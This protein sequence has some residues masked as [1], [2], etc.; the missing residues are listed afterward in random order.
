MT[1]S[2]ARLS[3]MGNAKAPMTIA[4]MRAGSTFAKHLNQEEWETYIYN[5]PKPLYKT[6]FFCTVFR[7]C[8]TLVATHVRQSFLEICLKKI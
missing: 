6:P 1:D 5:Y 2:A 4:A 3:A 8:F 7:I